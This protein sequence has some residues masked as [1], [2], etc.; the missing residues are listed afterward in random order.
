MKH[1]YRLV[2]SLLLFVGFQ[3]C[4][5]EDGAG[6][7]SPKSLIIETDEY[8]LDM[9]DLTT[10]Q[11]IAFRWVDVGNA[12]YTVAFTKASD[13]ATENTVT[14]VL[15]NE[16][17]AEKELNVLSMTI[18]KVQLKNYLTKVGFTQ[19]GTYDVVIS[20]TATPIDLSIPTALAEKGSV[21]SAVIHVTRE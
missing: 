15:S 6:V 20:I 10:P 7:P 14:E 1:F 11:F 5:D 18:S 3:S 13:A 12:A 8:T 17:T 21:K 16:V 4:V 2:V 9:T 19:A